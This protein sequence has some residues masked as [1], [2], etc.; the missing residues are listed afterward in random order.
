MWE[1]GGGWR[2]ASVFRRSAGRAGFSTKLS[3]FQAARLSIKNKTSKNKHSGQNKHLGR[4]E[5]QKAPNELL[6][7]VDPMYDCNAHAVEISGKPFYLQRFAGTRTGSSH[8]Q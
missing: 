3:S 6:A 2:R 1:C 7:T 8:G 4:Q 5:P